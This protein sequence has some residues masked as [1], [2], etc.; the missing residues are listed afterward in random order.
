V[1]WAGSDDGY[2]H[3]SRDNGKGWTK[4]NIPDLPEFALISIIDPSP[5]DAAT[6]YVAATR[7]KLADQKPYLYKTRDFGATWTK[8]TN[9]IPDHDFTRAIRE[10]P[11]RE[12]LLYAGTER[13]VYVSFND[14]GVWQPLSNELPV[15]PIHDLVVKN[16][17][18][19]A[20]THGRSFWILDNVA[21]L[22][23]FNGQ[24]MGDAVHLFQP[25]PTVRFRDRANLV[26][27]STAPSA[28]NPPAGVVVPY[29]F[30]VKPSG[31][32]TLRILKGTEVI[33]TVAN[34]P[35]NAGANRYLWDM[36]YPGAV[37]LP[38][39]VFQGSAEGP[40]APPGT[41]RVELA[42]GGQTLSQSFQIL[43]DPRIGYTD[44][45]LV[46]Q[47]EFLIQ[48]RDK[49]TE[50]MALVKRIR[51]LRSQA[52]QMVQS[53]GGR[54]QLQDALKALNDQ[55]YPLEERLVQYRARANQDLIAQPTGVDSKLARLMVFAS[56]AD[57]PPTEG[58]REL[59]GRLVQI[60]QERAEALSRIQEKEFA[61]L[62][63]M[64]RGGR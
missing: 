61:A 3:V 38:D 6:A 47:F 52:E 49:L 19:A 11:E 13:T 57:A 62:A 42:A 18:L 46:A 24:A 56:M 45:D 10:D 14:G 17:D 43:R 4:V 55:L 36:R 53:A 64:A 54:K 15:V 35:A 1:L 21:L 9:G 33:R 40:L 30:K 12:G 60:I 31:G 59:Y 5:H 44:A 37:V 22:H 27:R 7:Y 29:Y 48:A 32:V 8:I 23:Q 16:G 20:A 28:P 26:A 63:R 50:T 25:R 51:D 41:Y 58:D 34:A 2:V 39:A